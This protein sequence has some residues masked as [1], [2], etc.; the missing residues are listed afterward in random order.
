MDKLSD[1]GCES[2]LTALI[3]RWQKGFRNHPFRQFFS[4]NNQN[5]LTRFYSGLS[6]FKFIAEVEL[7][8]LSRRRDKFLHQFGFKFL[9]PYCTN[10][11]RR[12]GG[13][14]RNQFQTR[15][16]HAQQ[17]ARHERNATSGL[18]G[19]DARRAASTRRAKH[20]LPRRWQRNNE[21]GGVPCDF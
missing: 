12:Q 15:P 10:G 5:K 17:A 3:T 13:L 14:Q 19:G 16:D 11:N 2:T 9:A 18:D 4:L 1:R 8:I 21:G 6:L 7:G 20:F